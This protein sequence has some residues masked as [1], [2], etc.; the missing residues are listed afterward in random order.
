MRQIRQVLR[1]HL[2]ADLSY[3]QVARAVGI[4]K[5]TV[6]K[7]MLL[8]RAA[9]VDWGVAQTLSDQE[10]EA[11]LYRPAVPRSSRQL[12]PDYA[13][14][15]QELKRPGVT[16]QLLWEEYQRRHS[17]GGEPAYKYTSF[18]VKY[19]AWVMSL[20]RSM[21]Q[22]HAAGERLFVDYAGQTVPVIDAA[23]GEIRR[24]QIFVAVL[25][26]SNFTYACATATQT[27]ADWVG[28]IID[29]L[30]FCGG[31]PRLIVPD[32]PRALIARP[33]RYEPTVNR[34]VDEFCDH[35]DV[36]VLP[37]RPARPRDKPKVEVGVQVV[38]RW[39][40]AR[41]RNR[42]FFSLPEL[43]AAIAELLTDLNARPFKKLPGCRASA[44]TALDQ[45][46]LRPLP[47]TRMPIARFKRARVNI[48]Y[49]IELDGHY[50]SVPHR[51]V[52]TL[53]ELRVTAT[54]VEI[55]SGNQRVA[56]HPYSARRGAHT[57]TA[58]HMP[59]SHRAH[60]EWTPAKLIAW[61]ERI[62]AATAGV[63]RWQM[64]HR[65]HPEQGYRACLGLQRLARQFG[66]ARLEAA[67]ARA[68]SIRSPT[69]RSV[70]SILAAGLDRQ[71]VS[72]EPTQASLPLHDNVRG[73]DYY[74]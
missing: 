51:L 67:C 18:C 29:A 12:E 15:H 35:Y 72:A 47:A 10:L 3:A 22:T 71:Q 2:E 32:Q 52:R 68:L 4:G 70:N 13:W 39:I 19:R 58:E 6:G 28:S 1:L 55:L 21:R 63:V 36:A 50:Y 16:L 65:P 40:L 24:A 14:I 5:G 60:R 64:E 49:H 43:N 17:E 26:A 73:P 44:F 41:L 53:V 42:R 62:G 7:F 48:D 30:E 69:Y 56:V 59:A 74:H 46:A 54:T 9:G 11:R 57:T 38:E 8:A 34:L 37:A 20:K 23:S 61:G 25:G 27:T 33:D 45:Q 66:D 31:V